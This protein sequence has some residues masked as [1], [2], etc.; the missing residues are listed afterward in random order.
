MFALA[1][2]Q[3][4]M[5]TRKQLL[6]LGFNS[7]AIQ[8]RIQRRRL[9]VVFPGVYK[10][11]TPE[12]TQLG[13]WMAAVLRCG[14]GAVISH[15]DAAALWGFRGRRRLGDVHVTVRRPS[16]LR[17]RGIR[18]HRRPSLRPDE[19]TRHHGI[20]VTT[21]ATTIVDLAEDATPAE[22]DEAISGA[23][24]RGLCTPERVLDCAVAAGKR[25]GA[26]R[27]RELIARRTFRFRTRSGLE[28]AFLP[29]AERAGLPPPLTRQWLNGYEV[30]FYWPELGLVVETDGGRFHR[31]PAQQTRDRLRDQAHSAAGLVVLR[32]TEEQ[33]EYT[34]AHVCETLEAVVRR[35]RAARP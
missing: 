15:L 20:P 14:P 5:V 13:L 17:T 31:T 3:H 18:A 35:L 7:D 23:D 6:R 24:V 27:V 30:D 8:H 16:P 29:L 32:F 1:K 11:G 19:I 26:K 22:L 21:P 10:V 33:I 2:T 9:H 12:V 28:R 25:P 34:P 4:G